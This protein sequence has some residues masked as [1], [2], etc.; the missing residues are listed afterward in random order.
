MAQGGANLCR[1]EH[2]EIPCAQ[3]FAKSGSSL[4]CSLISGGLVG[5]VG[6]MFVLGR[7]KRMALS[8]PGSRPIASDWNTHGSGQL[9]P[10]RPS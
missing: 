10:D 3:E 1:F 7:G 2:G 9:R 5:V 4:G 8:G 6:N